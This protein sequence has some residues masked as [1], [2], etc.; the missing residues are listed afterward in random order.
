MFATQ[1]YTETLMEA[2]RKRQRE[3][4]ELANGT[5]GFLEHRNVSNFFL[6]CHILHLFWQHLLT[7]L[8]ETSSMSSSAHFADADAANPAFAHNDAPW[9]AGNRWLSR[10]QLFD[11][12]ESC[13]TD[14]RDGIR[15]GTLCSAWTLAA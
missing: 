5:A 10:P 1:Q 6:T 2:G 7:T 15:R 11:V 8:L 12:A 13:S 9:H 14:G 3:E 4:A